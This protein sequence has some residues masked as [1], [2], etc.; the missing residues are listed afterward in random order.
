[1]L[2]EDFIVA[3][4]PS[5]YNAIIGYPFMKKTKKVYATF[6]LL[7]KFSTPMGI[8]YISDN[9]SEARSCH[10]HS[11]NLVHKNLTTDVMEIEQSED[12]HIALENFN[13]KD[14]AFKPQPVEETIKA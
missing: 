3:Y 7:I 11:L 8:G 4:E 6:C 12:C 10:L 13:C 14:D 9:Y 1:M 2:F 5:V